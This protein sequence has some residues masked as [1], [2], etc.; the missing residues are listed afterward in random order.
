MNSFQAYTVGSAF[1]GLYFVVS[2]PLFFSLDEPPSPLPPSSDQVLGKNSG[3]SEEEEEA[4]AGEEDSDDDEPLTA[5]FKAHLKSPS[6][7][8]SPATRTRSAIATMNAKLDRKKA[9]SPWDSKKNK[10]NRGRQ[11]TAVSSPDGEGVCNFTPHTL[12]SCILEAL[13]AGMLVLMLLDIVRVRDECHS[14]LI[15]W[16]TN[17]MFSNFPTLR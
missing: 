10:T 8:A 9:K 11:S 15:K 4:E 13:A 16:L 3:A 1:Y 14:T 12:K 7:L 17:F 2:Y 5:D 6:L